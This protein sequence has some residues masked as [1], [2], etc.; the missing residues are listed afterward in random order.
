MSIQN[1]LDALKA[2]LV[3]IPNKSQPITVAEA[4]ILSDLLLEL[5]GAIQSIS[6]PDLQTVLDTG[7]I[8]DTGM[9]VGS[10]TLGSTNELS[11]VVTAATASL[12]PNAVVELTI[13]GFVHKIAAQKV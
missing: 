6:A 3:R 10:I 9:T 2:T 12:T 11:G 8:S 4:T 5:Y 1:N 7:N 13:D